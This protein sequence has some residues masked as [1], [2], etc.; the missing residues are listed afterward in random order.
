VLHRAS[1]HLEAMVDVE[2]RDLRHLSNILASLRASSGVVQVE[3][4]RG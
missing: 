4:A 2:V 3:R 1:D